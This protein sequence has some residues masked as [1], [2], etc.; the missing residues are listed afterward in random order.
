MIT[1]S[2][3]IT[4]PSAGSQSF[5]WFEYTDW[6]LNFSDF[7]DSASSVS[8][9][10]IV[11]TDG[12]TTATVLQ[13]GMAPDAWEI[14][15]FRDLLDDLEDA[16][17]NSLSSSGSIVDGDVTFAWQWDV[18]LAPGQDFTTLTQ[19]SLVPEPGLL[20][21]L[22]SGLFGLALLRRRA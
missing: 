20:A 9:T 6:D 22:G 12:G 18:N 17:P 8:A 10:A 15:V 7:D 21:L 19:T 14:D 3:T 13:L 4:N 1:K 16:F 11:Q 5:S 2:V